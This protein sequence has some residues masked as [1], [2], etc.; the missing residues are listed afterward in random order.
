[1]PPFIDLH[2]STGRNRSKQIVAEKGLEKGHSTPG[3][4]VCE[5]DQSGEAGVE[6][7]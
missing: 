4:T 5:V 7:L 2:G 6:S 3:W 1:M